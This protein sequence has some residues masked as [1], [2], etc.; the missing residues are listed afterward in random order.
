MRHPILT[1]CALAALAPACFTPRPNMRAEDL[2]PVEAYGPRA[3]VL[4]EP[5][6]PAPVTV[7]VPPSDGGGMAV[8]LVTEPAGVPV[9]DDTEA[10]A[11]DVEVTFDV[12]APVAPEVEDPALD[13]ALVLADRPPM[14]PV[15][16][17]LQPVTPILT[18]RPLP[19]ADAAPDHGHDAAAHAAAAL[20]PELVHARGLFVH[21]CA[22]CHGEDGSGTGPAVLDRP[23]RD[24]RN[25][26]FSFG[27]TEEALFRTLSKGIPGSPM[28]AFG[29]ALSDDDRRALARYVQFL[30]PPIAA[31]ADADTHLVVGDEAVMV[32]GIL[33]P[34][35][36]GGTLVPRGLIVGTPDGFSFEYRTDDVDLLA[37][38]QGAF[39][40][41]TDWTGRGGSP[42]EPLGALIW[43][44]SP[45][46][47][48]G[49]GGLFAVGDEALR[50]RLTSSAVDGPRF[51][52]AY[53]LVHATRGVVARVVESVTPIGHAVGAGFRRELDVTVVLGGIDLELRRHPA[54]AS[55]RHRGGPLP[56]GGIAWFLM[57]MTP[58][59]A[60]LWGVRRPGDVVPDGNVRGVYRLALDGRVGA[61]QRVEVST[62]LAPRWTPLKEHDLHAAMPEEL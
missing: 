58:E 42:L 5:A 60:E 3:V 41:R 51:R 25:G 36:E 12:G 27:N 32:R 21:N 39:V 38:R 17:T 54:G 26:G 16:A 40:R 1:V 13:A 31:V 33:P 53:D 18:P 34:R 23:A 37:V 15:A 45:G 59:R 19:P 9:F 55:L 24:F 30:G 4:E 11:E 49:L 46:A 7:V 8:T 10:L 44:A 56:T 14:Q 20:T 47:T 48:E 2:D 6:P 62:L 50:A 22:R 43:S 52:L 28:P 61:P 57:G 35:G 29:E